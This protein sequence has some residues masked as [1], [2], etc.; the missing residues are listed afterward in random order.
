VS[1]ADTEV[2]SE[3][4]RPSDE[5]AAERLHPLALLS[6]FG[7]A[8]RQLAGAL[9]AGGFVAFQSN[10]AVGVGIITTLVI[11]IFVSLLL[12]WLRFSFR[13]GADT[14]SIDSGILS[15]NSRT[16][17]FDR[18]ADVSVE[19]GPLQRL[20][21]VARVTLETG[22]GSVLGSE[23]GV[24]AAIR[25]TR[26]EA[27]RDQV[28]ARRRSVGVGAAG[29]GVPDEEAEAPL[30]FAMA[31]R[32]VLTAG[33][34]NFSLALFAGLFGISQTVGDALN[35]DPFERDFW[36]PLLVDS[37]FGDYLLEH[38]L[39]FALSGAALLVV[40][41][42]L[43]GVIRTALREWGFRLTRAGRG[44]R[45][46][47]GLL[48]R[49]DVTLPLRRVQAGVI[50]TGPVRERFGFHALKVKSLAGERGEPGQMAGDHALAPLA[51]W[52]ELRPIAA[53]LRWHLPG[54]DTAWRPVSRAHVWTFLLVL[55]AVILCLAGAATAGLLLLPDMSATEIARTG[56]T[57]AQRD[58]GGLLLI[59]LLALSSFAFVAALR[60]L[61]WRRT[62]Y[63][64]EQDRLLIRTGWWSR[65]TLLLPLRNVQSVDVQETALTRQFGVAHVVIGIAGGSWSGHRVPS[66][67]RKEASELRH[68][69]LAHQP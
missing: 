29:A 55:A 61:E 4:A 14:L 16:I 65:Q 3:A 5:P 64:L 67:P 9:F 25:L 40:A 31:P 44:L 2:A 24:L 37:G 39:G 58:G 38:R 66:L 69:L 32:R 33:L 20:F 7:K 53:S 68:L 63:A 51:R 12:N 60:W 21:G 15:R 34:F 28:R 59:G 54:E 10:L 13:V 62:F 26:A 23:E 49:T 19:Q 43:T 41:G 6:G 22:G 47:R 56:L 46:Q 50:D 57:T 30:L 8:V 36:R 42:L 52:S 27:L 1:E 18:V 11:F 35:V 48:T 17:P 45:R